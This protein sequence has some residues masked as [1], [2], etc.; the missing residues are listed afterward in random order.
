V[1]AFAPTEPRADPFC[2]LAND[3]EDELLLERRHA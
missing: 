3:P 2:K 1:G